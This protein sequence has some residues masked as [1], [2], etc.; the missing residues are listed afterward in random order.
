[1]REFSS[2]R[3]RKFRFIIC[4]GLL[5]LCLSNPRKELTDILTDTF[6]E[7]ENNTI[8]D[9]NLITS[10][11]IPQ[12]RS[13]PIYSQTFPE[14]ELKKDARNE[15]NGTFGFYAFIEKDPTEQ[16]YYTTN[17]FTN[18]TLDE[19]NHTHQDINISKFTMDGTVVW[20][21]TWGDNLSNFVEGMYLAPNGSCLYFVTT[22]YSLF[23]PEQLILI[24]I[25]TSNGAFMWNLTFNM[26]YSDDI[27]D[28]Y[29]T[30]DGHFLYLGG[31]SKQNESTDEAAL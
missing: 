29:I 21:T 18:F 1:M 30:N 19:Y 28:G 3:W 15:W 26:G 10:E 2:Q 4:V 31:T 20:N 12:Q 5:A 24:A 14:R 25:N 6:S 7:E 8:K 22:G 9:E 13:T 23:I 16:F 27:S 17:L 11:K